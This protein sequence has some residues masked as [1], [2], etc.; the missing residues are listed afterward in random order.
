MV[1]QDLILKKLALIETCVTELRTMARPERIGSDIREERFIAH[2]LQ[3]AIQAALDAA[4]HI[5]SAKRLGEP[6]S[7]RQLFDLLANAGWLRPDLTKTMRN[8]ARFRNI[9]VHGY[10]DIDLRIMADLIENKLDDFE[11]FVAE[12]RGGLDDSLA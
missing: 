5:V 4:S 1:D 9:L 11:F 10:E 3:L 2:T 6:K 8:M 12:I 7:Y